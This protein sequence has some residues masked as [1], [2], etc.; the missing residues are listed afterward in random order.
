MALSFVPVKSKEDQKLLADIA[1]KIWR[2]YWPTIIGEAQTE[3][4]IDSSKAKT[5]AR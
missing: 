1:G 4:M 2:G 3:Y 5:W